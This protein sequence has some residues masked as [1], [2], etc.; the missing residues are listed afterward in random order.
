[1][2]LINVKAEVQASLIHSR[3]KISLKIFD[4]LC[5]NKSPW[6]PRFLKNVTNETTQL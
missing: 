1:M 2:H 5:F 6:L 3:K 4:I